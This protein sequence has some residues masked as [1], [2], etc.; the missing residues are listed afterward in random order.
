MSD[1]TIFLEELASLLRKHNVTS[2][3]ACSCCAAINLK[4]DGVGYDQ[5][6]MYDGK[7]TIERCDDNQSFEVPV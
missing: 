7:L 2:F 6:G 4:I 5:G 1:P 3:W